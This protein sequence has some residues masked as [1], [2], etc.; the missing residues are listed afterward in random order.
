MSQI[1][2]LREL[3]PAIQE[4]LLFLPKTLSGPDRLYERALRDIAQVIDWE[5]QM[6]MFRLLIKTQ[7]I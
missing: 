3:A 1:M 5:R 2:L 4:E 6:E 7:G